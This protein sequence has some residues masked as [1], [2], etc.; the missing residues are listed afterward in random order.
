MFIKYQALIDAPDYSWF[1]L[2]KNVKKISR[3][4]ECSAMPFSSRLICIVV[5]EQEGIIQEINL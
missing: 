3:Q 2:P 1:L 5:V 4:T